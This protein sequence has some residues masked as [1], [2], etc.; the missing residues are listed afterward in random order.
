LIVDSSF[1]HPLTK[2]QVRDNY[3]FWRSTPKRY[4]GRGICIVYSA[5]PHHTFRVRPE[6]N[7]QK[8]RY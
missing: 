6:D 4:E 7:A 3:R 8:G 2:R 1:R 5:G